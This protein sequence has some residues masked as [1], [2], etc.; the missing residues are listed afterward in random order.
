MSQLWGGS[1]CTQGPPHPIRPLAAFLL[2]SVPKK[3]FKGGR[4]GRDLYLFSGAFCKL[5]TL[6]YFP[7][8]VEAHLSTFHR[9]IHRECKDYIPYIKD[10]AG[11]VSER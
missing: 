7:T 8:C 5:M 2:I 11:C 3:C 1:L 4:G 10:Q 6:R 9:H